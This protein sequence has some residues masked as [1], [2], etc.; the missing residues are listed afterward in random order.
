MQWQSLGFKDNPISTDPIISE[1]LSLYV[2]HEQQ[3]LRCRHVLGQRNIFMVIEGKRGVGTT[4]FANYLR[5]SAQKEQLYFTPRNEIRVEAGWRLD[6]LLAVIV[7]NIVREIELFSPEKATK[8][9][10]FQDAKALSMRIAEAY[11]SFGVEAFGFGINY[12][13]SAGISSMPSVVP[14]SVIGHHLEDLSELILSMGYK[15]GTL[16]Q[17]N[18]LDIGAIHDE[19]HM[20]YLFNAIRDYVQTKGMTWLFV[21]DVGLRRFIAQEVDRLDDIV[22]YEVKL[23]PLTKEEFH[24]LIKTRVEYYRENDNA[25]L[26]VDSEVLSYLYDITRGRLRYI[27]GLLQRLMSNLHVGD[28]TDRV[29]LDIAKPMIRQLAYDRVR[30]NDISPIEEQLLVFL[31][32]K[33]SSTVTELASEINKTKQYASKILLKLSDAKLVTVIKQGKYRSYAPSLDAIIAYS[34]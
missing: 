7:A 23:D 30:L 11:R 10:R 27:F 25:D 24:Q 34:D 29:S 18:N 21:G 32:K 13:K 1:T 4:S 28:L 20:K 31:V 26:P 19:E 15:Y 14:S 22:N 2:G 5:F 33:E 8:D 12:G 3:V 9:K 17:L 6:T 16:I